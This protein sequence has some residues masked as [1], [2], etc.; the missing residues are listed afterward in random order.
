MLNLVCVTIVCVILSDST[1]KATEKTQPIG[2]NP[3]KDTQPKKHQSNIVES[4]D[5]TKLTLVFCEN[6]SNNSTTTT[7]TLDNGASIIAIVTTTST[8]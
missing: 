2:K 3:S 6:L 7:M 1:E 8:A 4:E 5:Q